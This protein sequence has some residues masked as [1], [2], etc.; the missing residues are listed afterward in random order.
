[1]YTQYNIHMEHVS[2]TVEQDYSHIQRIIQ[3]DMTLPDERYRA[4][5]QAKRLLL[6][7]AHP[8]LTPRMTKALRKRAQN[9][10]HHYPMEFE[11]KMA[12]EACPSVFRESLDD[13]ERFILQGIDKVDK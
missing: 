5:M 1:M 9:I 8:G 10:L 13:V 6:D 11:L 4:V 3:A 7:L 12:A 2:Y